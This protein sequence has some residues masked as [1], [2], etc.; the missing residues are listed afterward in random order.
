MRHNHYQALTLDILNL[1]WCA[2][3]T[4]SGRLHLGHGHLWQLHLL[5]V[6]LWYQ[7]PRWRLVPLWHLH[8]LHKA[9]MNA[10]IVLGIL[11]HCHAAVIVTM[12][13]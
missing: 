12:H 9:W 10:A 11:G 13:L 4:C 3:T 6:H 1:S 7:H 2:C 5:H 8:H